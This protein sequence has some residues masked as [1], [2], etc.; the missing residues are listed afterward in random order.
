MSRRDSTTV[1]L[2]SF[3]FASQPEIVAIYQLTQPQFEDHPSEP[4]KL[5]I[6]NPETVPTGVVPLSFPPDSATGHLASVIVEVT[7]GEFES[8]RSGRLS[9]PNDWK[10]NAVPLLSRTQEVGA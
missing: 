1:E 9:L 7:P 4:I 10:F 5:L 8:I 3:Y 6:V 2:A